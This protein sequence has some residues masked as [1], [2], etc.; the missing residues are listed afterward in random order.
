[1]K[2][3]NYMNNNIILKLIG[4]QFANKKYLYQNALVSYFVTLKI[5]KLRHSLKFNVT[6]N[7]KKNMIASNNS[8]IHSFYYGNFT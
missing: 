7:L 1:M 6:T 5:I 3:H 8:V 2:Q 4:K